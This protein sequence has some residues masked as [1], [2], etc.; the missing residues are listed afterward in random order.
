MPMV[1][2]ASGGQISLA[3]TATGPGSTNRSMSFEFK[4]TTTSQT[5]LSEYYRGGT[6]VANHPTNA[7]VAT[8]G[9]ISI[10]S[11]Y[12]A[13]KRYIVTVSISSNTS[14]Y[15][16]QTSSVS[17]YTAGWTDVALVINSG[18]T[19][20]ASAGTTA[21][22][23]TGF[24]SA[25]TIYIQNSGTIQGGGGGGGTATGGNGGHGINLSP[26]S[27]SNV[28]IFNASGAV[29]GGGGGGGGRGQA[30]TG[31]VHDA[32]GNIISNSYTYMRGGG[33]GGG[34]GNSAGSGSGVVGS[35]ANPHYNY[36]STA[37]SG[38]GGSTTAGG[39]GGGPD[40]GYI[41]SINNYYVAS[42][43]SGGA[44]GARG[45]NGGG[46][47]AGYL[48]GPPGVVYIPND[49]NATALYAGSTKG[50]MQSG[51][52]WGSGG[53]A[54]YAVKGTNKLASPVSNSGTLYGPQGT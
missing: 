46:G 32:Y 48:N 37:G 54:G 38:A 13:S 5:S 41:Y 39:G 27:A 15:N 23:V 17:G 4:S 12:G 9:A 18:V 45:A 3:G 28:T 10:G 31:Y 53:S 44:G 22:T 49:G 47:N 50:V 25:D 52:A 7:P 11:F 51:G 40:S 2:S 6:Y 43:G 16:L 8:S 14:N 1:S 21:L 29:I 30:I 34:A 20:N 42:A 33:G 19:V 24:N 26:A 36:I 35:G